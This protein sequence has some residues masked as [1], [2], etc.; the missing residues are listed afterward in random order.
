MQNVKSFSLFVFFFT[1]ALEKIFI[2]M[3]RAE[4]RCYRTR[5]QTVFD[6]HP[7]IFQPGN[8]TGWGSEGVKTWTFCLIKQN[9]NHTSLLMLHLWPT[10][11]QHSSLIHFVSSPVQARVLVYGVIRWRW[12]PVLCPKLHCNKDSDVTKLCQAIT[13]PLHTV[14]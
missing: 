4:W 10:G 1:L 2:K 3:H 9:K 14:V 12:A 11:T 13:N 6:V 7:C 8:S 5:K